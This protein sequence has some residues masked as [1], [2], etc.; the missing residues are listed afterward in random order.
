MDL[1]DSKQ[2]KSFPSVPLR[3]L[4]HAAALFLPSQRNMLWLPN[5]QYH[6]FADPNAPPTPPYPRTLDA[7]PPDSSPYLS[8]RHASHESPIWCPL[9]ALSPAVVSFST[10][11]SH[12]HLSILE[13]LQS[14]HP[15]SLQSPYDMFPPPSPIL[16]RDLLP[17]LVE[18]FHGVWEFLPET[19]HHRCANTIERAPRLTAWEAL[20]GCVSL[21]YSFQANLDEYCLF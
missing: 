1:D 16:P 3:L 14:S 15:A 12:F 9:P 8:Q 17:Q 19:T 10:R 21:V 13:H 4:G 2:H 5:S 11:T 6:L 18:P 20:I 7:A